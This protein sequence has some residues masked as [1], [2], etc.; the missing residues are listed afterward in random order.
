MLCAI[1]HG[2]R[3]ISWNNSVEQCVYIGPRQKPTRCLHHKI[4]QLFTLFKMALCELELIGLVD[5][6]DARNCY[7]ITEN[8]H[9]TRNLTAR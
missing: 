6:R 1:I 8:L 9:L 7:P 4:N 3:K 5:Y 2:N